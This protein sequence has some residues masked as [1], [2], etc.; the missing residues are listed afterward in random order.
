MVK[1][2]TIQLVEFTVISRFLSHLDITVSL[3]NR[4]HWHNSAAEYP[5]V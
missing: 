2:N 4:T 1:S 3:V 5:N